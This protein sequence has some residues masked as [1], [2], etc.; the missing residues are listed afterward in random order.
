M[1]SVFAGRECRGKYYV[2]N[3]KG[4]GGSFQEFDSATFLGFGDDY[5]EFE[6]GPAQYTTAIVVLPDGRV[7]TT[8]PEFI[9]FISKK[10]IKPEKPLTGSVEASE[11]ANDEIP[12]KDNKDGQR[13]KETAKRTIKEPSKRKRVDHG[14]IRALKNE[15][16]SN[17]DIADEMHMTPRAVANSL[18]THKELIG[19]LKRI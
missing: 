16:W 19:E 7:A 12:S 5:E 1:N 14:K 13:D 4:A 15:G 3:E 11:P 8:A 9:Q 6:S 10:R 18:S 17:K 2:K